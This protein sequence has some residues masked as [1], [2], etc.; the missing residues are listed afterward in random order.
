MQCGLIGRPHMYLYSYSL[1]LHLDCLVR[2]AMWFDWSSAH[3]FE[4]LQFIATLRLPCQG[5]SVVWI[6]RPHMYLYSY[7]LLLH[8]VC[9]VRGAM[10]F[11]W[12]SAHV[13]EQLQFI[14]TLRPP[15]QG[16]SVVWLV[17]RICICTVTVYCYTSIVKS[18]KSTV[19]YLNVYS[20]ILKYL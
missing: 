5:C 2:G 10:W 7:I 8:L 9:L 16:C 19:L 20:A 14:A 3:V 11:D 12:S 17:V 18:P 15:C 13:F 4:Q 6:G 1:L